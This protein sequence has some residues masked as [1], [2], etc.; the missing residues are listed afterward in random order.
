MHCGANALPAQTPWDCGPGYGGGAWLPGTAVPGRL[1]GTLTIIRKRLLAKYVAMLLL[2]LGG[3]GANPADRAIDDRLPVFAGIP[4]LAYLVEQIGGEYVKVDVLVQPGQDPHTF[5]SSPQQI[6]ALGR[7]AIFFKVDMPFENVLLRKVLE[8]NPRLTVVDTTR[9]IK[10]RPMETPCR[11]QSAGDDHDHEAEAGEP[12]P[13]VWLSPP[14]LMT[15][16]ENIAAGLCQVDPTHK[17]AYQRNLAVLVKRLK[18]VHQRIEKM[19]TPYRGRSF[20]V[21]HPGFGYFA[22]AYGLKQ[23]AVE[24]G[25]HAPAPKQLQV[26]IEKAHADRVTTIF[27]QPQFSPQSG[28]VAAETLGGKVVPIN[29]LGKNVIEDIEDIAVKVETAM[30][31]SS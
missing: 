23:E 4:P 28:Q 27:V 29:G 7:A 6:F 31:T 13:H 10:K 18:A 20:Y 12:D 14:L 25:G 2:L 30:K 5:E 24:A 21:F 15:E 26:L 17:R 22:D 8:G 16:A 9:G 11:D 19:L 1:T 3:C